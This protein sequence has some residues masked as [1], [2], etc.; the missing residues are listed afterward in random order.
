MS[1][2]TGL[3][4]RRLTSCAMVLA[5]FATTSVAQTTRPVQGVATVGDHVVTEEELDLLAADRLAR[6]K[7][8]QYNIRRVVLDEYITRTLMEKEAKAR[9]ITLQQ[10]E[11]VEIDAKVLP[12]TEDQK[13]AVYETNSAQFQGKSE[14]EAFAQIEANL[15]R[16]RVQEARSRL[17]ASL[18]LKTPVKVTL[19]APR[20]NVDTGDAPSLGPTDATVTMVTFSD[21]Q[22]PACGRSYPTVKRIMDQYKGRIRFV[23]RDFPLSIHPQA[24]KAAEAAACANE[25]GKFWQMHDAMFENQ[26]KL[27]VSDLKSTAASLGL[28]TERFVACLDSGKKTADWQADME[29]GKKYGVNSTP[30]FFINGRLIAGAAPYPAFAQIID[31]ELQRAGGASPAVRDEDAGLLA[32]RTPLVSKQV[33][34]KESK[35]A[36][37]CLAPQ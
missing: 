4:V 29:A 25:Q 17:M 1:L 24:P 11:Q 7:T 35:A 31:E 34:T 6:L 3:V 28:D 2:T 23:F 14:V 36:G 21:F 19:A 30:S 12:V 22:C 16:V 13:R 10:L 9:G 5:A 18:R 27:A 20:T 26:Q 8:E 15:K 33:C 32:R 37:V